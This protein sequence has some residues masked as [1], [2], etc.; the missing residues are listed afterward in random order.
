MKVCFFADVHGNDLSFERF[1]TALKL[2]NDVSE[3]FFLGDF[4]GYYYNPNDI[5]THCRLNHFQ[6]IL[7]NHDQTFLNII[8]GKV[9]VEKMVER[10]GHS[11]LKAIKTISVEN[12]NFLRQLPKYMIVYLE[13]KRL[14]LCHGSPED[15]LN[16]R[17]Y[18]DT[19]LSGYMDLVKKYDY[20][21]TGHTHHK[22]AKPL[23]TLLFLNPGSLGQQRDGL[24]C[25]YLILDLTKNS[26]NFH[27]VKYDIT[28]LER[29]IDRYDDGWVRLKEVLRRIR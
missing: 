4:I 13:N 28:A 20:I 21:V 15:Y 19:D 23:G 27:T 6:C 1:A 2:T 14:L 25:S 16:G 22:L 3:V 17:I 5:I 9:K 7:G 24:G 11:Y 29:R 8:D 12:I 18:P 26:H 10:Y